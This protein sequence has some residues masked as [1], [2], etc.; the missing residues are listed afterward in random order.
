MTDLDHLVNAVEITATLRD[1]FNSI[2][3]LQGPHKAFYY[4]AGKVCEK[5]YSPATEE[6]FVRVIRAAYDEYVA[7]HP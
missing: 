6:K 2:A 4:F 1:G 7:A 3:D 5:G